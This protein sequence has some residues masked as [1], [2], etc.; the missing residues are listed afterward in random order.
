MRKDFLCE[1]EKVFRARIESRGFLR[2][3]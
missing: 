3:D 1:Q 2:F